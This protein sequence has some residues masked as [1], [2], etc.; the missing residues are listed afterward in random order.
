[1]TRFVTIAAAVALIGIGVCAA[2]C[3]D[4]TFNN[5]YSTD[6]EQQVGAEIS[7]QID[8]TEKIDTDAADNSRV[9]LI[10]QAVFDQARKMRPDVQYQIKIIRSPEVNAFSLPGGY[11]YVYTGLLDKIGKDDDAL[12]AVI[13]HESAHIVRRHAVKQMSDAGIKE[14]LVELLGIT[15]GSVDL[16]NVSAAAL[17]LEQLHYSREDEYEADK[18][19]LM[20]S[21]NAGYDPSGMI[22]MFQKLE[23]IESSGGGEPPYAEDHPITKNRILRARELAKILRANHGT[24]PSSTDADLAKAV[25]ETSEP[26]PAPAAPS[27][28]PS[29]PSGPAVVSP[30]AGAAPDAGSTEAPKQQTTTNQD[31]I[32]L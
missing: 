5:V 2:G 14:S 28:A 9:Q 15:T 25:P 20:F 10:A 11:V 7:N 6:Q 29:M 18:Y 8:S 31:V 23:G 22:R 12:A 1:L 32:G 27:A 21:Y 4:E 19:G 30:A 26:A 24:Y 17:E 13:G 3:R 16:Y